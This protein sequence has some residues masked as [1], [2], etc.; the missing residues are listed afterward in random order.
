MK[1]DIVLEFGGKRYKKLVI[2]SKALE[3]NSPNSKYDKSSTIVI[4][5]DEEIESI[6]DVV[7]VLDRELGSAAKQRFLNALFDSTPGLSTKGLTNKN[8]KN[9][10]NKI[11]LLDNCSFDR[12]KT[13]FPNE[14]KV[15]PSDKEGGYHISLIT[16][17][18]V[19]GDELQGRV[20]ANGIENY[21]LRSADDVKR[22]ALTEAKKNLVNELVNGNEIG[23]EEDRGSML[24]D[25]YE[26][27]LKAI[28][29]FAKG[30]DEIVE[31]I[32]SELNSDVTIQSVL[33]DY[34]NHKSE[35]SGYYVEH[36]GKVFQSGVLMRDFCS[37][38]NHDK[39]LYGQSSESPLAQALRGISIKRNRLGKDSLYKLL[40][41]FDPEYMKDVS[42][43]DFLNMGKAEMTEL[44]NHFFE[45][46]LLLQNF[47]VTDVDVTKE[48]RVNLTQQQINGLFNKTKKRLIKDATVESKPSKDLKYEDVVKTVADAKEWIG[49]V[50]VDKA[51]NEYTLNIQEVNGKITYSYQ[52]KTMSDE[53]RVYVKYKGT[54]LSDEFDFADFGHD[55]W[56]VFQ[57]A[58]ES[59]DDSV[60]DKVIDGKYHGYYIYQTTK[61]GQDIFII[62]KSVI[63]PDL[64]VS[65]KF[66]TLKDAKNAVIG[67]NHSMSIGK[68]TMHELKAFNLDPES[69]K[70]VRMSSYVKIGFNT[71][72]GQTIDVI[73]FYISPNI[74]NKLNIQEKDLFFSGKIKDVIKFYSAE[75]FGLSDDLKD[76]M[77]RILDT[78]EKAGT[79]V[80]ALVDRGIMYN[81]IPSEDVAEGDKTT[82][83]YG[84]NE[85]QLKAIDQ[86]LNE[87]EDPKFKQYVVR[88]SY[89]QNPD[90]KGYVDIQPYTTYIQALSDSGMTVNSSGTINLKGDDDNGN[91]KTISPL[92]SL[93]TSLYNLKNVFNNGIFK[94]TGIEIVITDN[95]SLKT[96]PDLLD[97]EGKSIFGEGFDP[98]V[99]KGF[100][101][102]NKIYINQSNVS[103]GANTM[104]HEVF[105]IMFGAIR[106]NDI[107]NGTHIYE[108]ILDKYDEEGK[109]LKAIKDRVETSYKN[110]AYLDKKEEIVVRYLARIMENG[111][112]LFY[113]N[114][115]KKLQD[116]TTSELLSLVRKTLGDVQEALS[117]DFK[118]DV[119]FKNSFDTLFKD[120]NITSEMTKQRIVANL[121]EDGIS[122]ELIEEDCK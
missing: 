35:Y 93:T 15:L 94:G 12:L 50:Y 65:G 121:I 16:G 63:H 95:E 106:A 62:S 52:S 91:P 61:N 56:N 4:P 60:D 40:T 39:I 86:V 122:S 41:Q 75:R 107:K 69:D 96:D 49:E 59:E 8:N 14:M 74:I 97:G 53:Q 77:K 73:D 25:R 43:A 80:L 3:V 1:C 85:E 6:E 58:D 83:K 38:L 19:N 102:N 51:G 108:D 68:G 79:F 20:F 88:R 47:E 84:L 113:A 112:S 22:F 54:V 24:K 104:F 55:S 82:K 33:I 27:K 7:K 72:P 119:E 101:Y 42:R 30:K 115:E 92:Q 81:T 9:S 44:L 76:K 46:D 71:S 78:P 99:I 36:D 45:G 2:T 111:S 100:V 23:I 17:A 70:P 11:T 29:E 32:K 28:V 31:R 34:L 21:I 13:L 105:H 117:F 116:Q 110:M 98:S 103:D 89:K 90:N 67:Y 87:L 114:N 37:E 120:K 64:Y 109:E 18:Y 118:S 57:K 48:S 66:A 10:I 26:D 5:E